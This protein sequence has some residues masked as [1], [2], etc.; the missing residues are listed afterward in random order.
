VVCI[1]A[2][3]DVYIRECRHIFLHAFMH[4][5]SNT[6]VI[7]HIFKR[8][9]CHQISHEGVYDIDEEKENI[10]P[11]ILEEGHRIIA[12]CQDTS[13]L[14]TNWTQCSKYLIHVIA[15]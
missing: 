4:F 15:C 10:P 6:D 12:K 14:L 9:L 1:Y 13:K 7:L 8:E 5:T 11:E 3:I 2:Y